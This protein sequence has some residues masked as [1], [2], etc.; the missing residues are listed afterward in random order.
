MSSCNDK[1]NC[2]CQQEHFVENFN[3]MSG[4]MLY[5]SYWLVGLILA[6]VMW[7]MYGRGT[8]TSVMQLIIAVFF[9]WFYIIAVFI[10]KVVF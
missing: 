8:D 1:K 3:P 7:N 4:I 5:M 6:L 9:N 2:S 10:S